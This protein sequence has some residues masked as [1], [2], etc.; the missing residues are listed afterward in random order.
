MC[1][2]QS[3][4]CWLC[5]LSLAIYDRNT[6]IV[7]MCSVFVF[8][9]FALLSQKF[10]GSLVLA[11]AVAP[12]DPVPQARTTQ[13]G[14]AARRQPLRPK[15]TALLPMGLPMG[16]LAYGHYVSPNCFEQHRSPTQSVQ[17]Q[18]GGSDHRARGRHHGGW[19]HALLLWWIG[20]SSHGCSVQ[21]PSH[22][23]HSPIHVY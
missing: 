6:D 10:N 15:A 17:C 8:C 9:L 2:A 3:K 5:G 20:P 13:N 1:S 21:S 19:V 7:Y 22:P 16:F 23:H 4:C 14:R 18:G 12:K 11:C